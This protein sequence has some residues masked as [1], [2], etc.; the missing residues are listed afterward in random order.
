M[1]YWHLGRRLL[2]ENLQQG[3]VARDKV[4]SMLF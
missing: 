3:R 2:E 1:L 4:G